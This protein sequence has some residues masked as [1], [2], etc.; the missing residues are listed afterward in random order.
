MHFRQVDNSDDLFL[1]SLGSG[2]YGFHTERDV[3]WQRLE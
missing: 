2:G 3:S 1:I